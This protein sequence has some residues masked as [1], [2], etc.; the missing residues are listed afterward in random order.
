[1]LEANPQDEQRNYAMVYACQPNLINDPP[2]QKV[3]NETL[4][5]LDGHWPTQRTEHKCKRD[6]VSQEPCCT[7]IQDVKRKVQWAVSALL[8]SCLPGIPSWERWLSC[9]EVEGYWMLGICCHSLFPRAW[10]IAYPTVA[11]HI[12][13]DPDSL[14]PDGDADNDE[15]P[16]EDRGFISKITTVMF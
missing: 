6:P 11:Q 13:V 5:V 2:R 8:I 7:C 4:E 1:M 15:R 16:N 14:A 10:A 12:R 3:V 9:V